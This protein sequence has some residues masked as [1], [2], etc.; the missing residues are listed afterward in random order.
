MLE[1]QNSP[2]MRRYFQ[3]SKPVL[4]LLW[5]AKDRSKGDQQF[6]Q[7]DS[8]F[9]QK[10]INPPPVHNDFYKIRSLHSAAG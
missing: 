8:I 1:S 5:N 2:I 6:L 3:R 9:T 4:N 10:I 7:E